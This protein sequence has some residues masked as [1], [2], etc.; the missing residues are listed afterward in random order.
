MRWR[1]QQGRGL[2]ST[3]IGWFGGGGYSHI[4]V[5]TPDGLLRGAR[6]DVLAGI[7]AGYQDRPADYDNA[8]ISRYTVFTLQ[9]TPQQE[10]RYW[11]FSNQQLGKPYDKRGILGF[12][13]G[14]RDWR[15]EDSWYCS[16]EVQANCEYA[17]IFQ[18]LP[19]ELWRVDPGDNA[20]EF[21]QKGAAW[22]TTTL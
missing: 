13:F 14:K 5:F 11:E 9:V 16:E 12:A 21:A 1:L 6:A 22:Q 15:E 10:K 2:V 20:F 19:P 8:N 7:P 4:D 17:G 18:P 3:S